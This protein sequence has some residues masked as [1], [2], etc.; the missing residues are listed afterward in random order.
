LSKLNIGDVLKAHILEFTADQLLLKL[1]DG[2][3]VTASSMVPLDVKKGDI[4]D[5]RVKEKTDSR[6]F[7]ETVKKVNPTT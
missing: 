6:I 3:T 2:T 1:M 7:I 5:F 4:V